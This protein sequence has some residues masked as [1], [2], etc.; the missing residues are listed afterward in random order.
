MIRRARPARAGLRVLAVWVAAMALIAP[1]GPGPSLAAADPAPRSEPADPVAAAAEAFAALRFDEALRLA[2][3][4][5]RNGDNGPDQLR[6]IFELA[7]RAAGSIGEDRA[8]RLWFSRWLYL[9][10]DAALP[11]G[12]SP[13]L[14]ALFGDAR[15]TLAGAALT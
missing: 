9:D 1:R 14:T 6:R 10:P 4:A 12:T 3:Q 8:A 5:W 15:A 11:D 7:G 2:D 13:K